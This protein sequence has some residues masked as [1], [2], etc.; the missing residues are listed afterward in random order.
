MRCWLFKGCFCRTVAAEDRIGLSQWYF[1]SIFFGSSSSAFGGENSVLS[2]GVVVFR[3]TDVCHVFAALVIVGDC[4]RFVCL[5]FN[6]HWKTAGR[7]GFPS[8]YYVAA[9]VIVGDCR[10]FV[11][12]LF[13]MHRQTAGRGGF[14]SP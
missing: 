14:P 9:L 2:V 11:C 3:L 1:S 4:R 12:L 8:P 5:L 7:G 13:N 10:R 6:M